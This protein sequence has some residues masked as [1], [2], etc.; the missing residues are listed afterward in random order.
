MIELL[1]FSL[2]D[3]VELVVCDLVVYIDKFLSFVVNLCVFELF[4]LT[5][6]LVL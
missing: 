1:I 2:V 3:F 4:I 6:L 5:R